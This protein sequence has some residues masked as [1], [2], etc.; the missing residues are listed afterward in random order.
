MINAYPVPN[1]FTS[2]ALAALMSV[3]SPDISEKLFLSGYVILF[4]LS[5]RYAVSAVSSHG[6]FL[7]CL[8]FPFTYN[9]LCHMGFYN[10]IYSIAGFFLLLGLWIRVADHPSLGGLSLLSVTAVLLYSCHLVSL[11]AAFIGIAFVALSR[12]IHGVVIGVRQRTLSFRRLGH[13]LWVHWGI[14]AVAFLPTLFL[15]LYFVRVAPAGSWDAWPVKALVTRLV[16]LQSLNSYSESEQWLSAQFVGLFLT[17][18]AYLTITKVHTRSFSRHDGY[19]V[20]TVV[21]LALYFAV[22]DQLLG[23]GLISDRL[24]LYPFFGAMLWFA[25]QVYEPWMRR[26]VQM[27]SATIAVMF[28]LLHTFKYADLNPYLAES[29]SGISAIE[30]NTTIL[31]LSLS[32]RGSS[33]NGTPLASRATPFEHLSGHVV[34]QRR[35]VDVK[36]YQARQGLFPLVIRPELNPLPHIGQIDSEQPQPD[37]A[38]YA[39]N[40]GRPIDYVIVWGLRD[41]RAAGGTADALLQDV[42]ERYDW[43]YTSAPRGL[44]RLYRRKDRTPSPDR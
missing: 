34:A 30:Y 38:A 36:N 37:W 7:A 17:I 25:T 32:R 42:E 18:A 22:P 12:T 16:Y 29:L 28:L 3:A 31:P 33:A 1:W 24:V 4:P 14:A 6:T 44:M 9:F 13:E 20:L 39:D 23:G 11:A 41:D 27:L 15:V 2:A 5:V 40:I 19:V 26:L 43:I 35:V 21:Y 8:A 10:F